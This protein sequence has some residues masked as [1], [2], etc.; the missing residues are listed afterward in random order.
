MTWSQPLYL[1][2]L[3]A[4]VLLAIGLVV[5]GRRALARLEQ[6]L[7]PEMALEVVPAST[8]AR[9]LA[10]DLLAVAGLGLVVLALAEPRFD[11]EVIDI[12]REGLD[13]ILVVD[14]SRSMACAD[15]DPSRMER[16]RREIYDLIELLQGDRVGLVMYA[17]AAYPRIPLTLDYEALRWM[18][19]ELSPDVFQLQ[20]SD[21]GGAIRT[22]VSMFP[23]EAQADKAVLV[24]S[25]GE[26]H[27]PDDVLAAAREAA[28]AN[29]HVYGLGIGVE[30]APVPAPGGGFKT[31]RSGATVLSTPS[32]DLLKD[33]ARITGGGFVPSVA[34]D[35]DLRQL[36][37]EEL[38]GRLATA[39]LSS[40]QREVWRSGYQLPLGVGLALM[41][42]GALLGDGRTRPLVAMLVLCM[43]APQAQAASRADADRLFRE[44]R[45]D[46]A[47]TELQDLLADAPDDADLL[48]RIAA[49]RYRAGDYEGAAR[50]WDRVADGSDSADAAYNAGNAHYRAGRAQEAVRRYQQ[51]LERDPAHTGAAQ[52]LQA[53]QQRLEEQPPQQQPQ[54]Q[55]QQDQDQ[56]EGEQQD[57]QDGEQQQDGEPQ[58]GEQQE[59]EQQEG[60]EQDPGQQQDGGQ[61]EQQQ[62]SEQQ[63]EDGEV[64]DQRREPGE[65]EP[66][67][68]G[69]DEL[70]QEPEGEGE[71]QGGEPIEPWDG[72]GP[73]S[74]AQA[75]RLLDGEEEGRPRIVVNGRNPEQDW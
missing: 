16:A 7:H 36:Y 9:R 60:S 12:E 73:M 24:L 43:L 47:L 29:V 66:G 68:A 57:Q 54:D 37:L 38:R 13:V 30:A 75:D 52:N 20:G 61:S 62:A 5:W 21:L 39:Q 65:D 50:T 40:R 27:D 41:L 28:E 6:L 46:E 55:D 2:A 14:L 71:G 3:V 67:M 19:P 4:V 26:A 31:D 63:G 11:K 53:V 33:V 8:R 35:A 56:Q 69:L 48:D 59:G 25:D 32:F 1:W 70:D 72:E 49:A 18:V 58:Q 22:A 51:A 64:G 45:Y 15:V 74:E 10:R 42:L 17:G 44:G 23:E 34:S